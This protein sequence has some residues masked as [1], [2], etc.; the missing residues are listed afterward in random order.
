MALLVTG[1]TC[2]ERVTAETGGYSKRLASHGFARHHI[3]SLPPEKRADFLPDTPSCRSAAKPPFGI[4]GFVGISG[5]YPIDGMTLLDV[6]AR[7]DSHG[8]QKPMQM[9]AIGLGPMGVGLRF[10]ERPGCAS[11]SAARTSDRRPARCTRSETATERRP[12][13]GPRHSA[14]LRGTT[15][16]GTAPPVSR[17]ARRG[18]GPPATARD[19]D[20]SSHAKE[21]GWRKRDVRSRGESRRRT[22]GSGRLAG[23]TGCGSSHSRGSA[24]Q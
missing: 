5:R 22:D 7:I 13:I 9:S 15:G 8:F 18:G 20:G 12:E 19:P 1:E 14:R 2:C 4:I 23:A 16:G 24:G 21:A 3:G 17:A 11:P 10:G 6:P